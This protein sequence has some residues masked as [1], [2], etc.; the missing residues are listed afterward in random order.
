MDL[1]Q[2]DT[3]LARLLEQRARLVTGRTDAPAKAVR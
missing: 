3:E 2:V 1:K